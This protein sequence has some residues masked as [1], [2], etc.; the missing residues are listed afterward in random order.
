MFGDSCE[1]SRTDLILVVKCPD[2]VRPILP[3]QH[4][5][6]APSTSL[7]CP[8]D[9][10][11]GGENA[12]CRCAASFAHAAAKETLSNGDASPFSRRSAS[13]RRA[14]ACAFA[15]ACFADS[16]YTS[17]PG[18]SATSAIHWPSSSR[19]SSTLKFMLEEYLTQPQRANAA[20]HARPP[21]RGGT[22]SLDASPGSVACTRSVRPP[23]SIARDPI[24][25]APR[26]CHDEGGKTHDGKKPQCADAQPSY[27]VNT[28]RSV[29]RT[30]RIVP[31][32]DV[33]HPTADEGAGDR[34][35]DQGAKADCAQS[36][37]HLA[38]AQLSTNLVGP[39]HLIER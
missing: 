6:R 2:I 15:C 13:T 3:R 16:P 25:G 19:A 4:A 20:S 10:E 34:T 33:H 17:T 37:H 38:T 35:E 1:H 22:L 11:Q 7:L 23:S 31:P 39:L 32:R 26:N 18:S 24:G 21:R 30:L 36:V 29:K 9:S 5:M 8:A 12:S 14:R 27:P 28:I